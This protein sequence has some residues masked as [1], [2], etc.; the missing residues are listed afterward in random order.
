M[1]VKPKDGRSVPDPARGDLLPDAGRNV[2]ESQYWYRR[3]QD[4][5]IEIVQQETKAESPKKANDK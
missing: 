2:E 4:G 5:D 1:L 3:E